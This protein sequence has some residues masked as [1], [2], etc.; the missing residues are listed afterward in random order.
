LNKIPL[1]GETKERMLYEL[2]DGRKTAKDLADLLNIQVSAARKH[3]EALSELNIVREEFIQ[4][5]IGRPKKFYRLTPE[6]MELF[7]RQY[8]RILNG[9]LG[10]L[11]DNHN[12]IGDTIIRSVAHELAGEMNLGEPD[13]RSTV[14]NLVGALNDFGFDSVLEEDESTFKI[15]SRNCPLYKAAIKHQKIVCHGLHDEM[16]KSAL[17][18]RDVKLELCVTRGDGV[19]KHVIDKRNLPAYRNP[20]QDNLH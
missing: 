20:L 10:K 11:R 15:T 5:G 13:G 17:N 14:E 7:P 19:C 16:I 8:E 12:V 9:V 18:T 3:L 2:K 4:D 1:L 6:G